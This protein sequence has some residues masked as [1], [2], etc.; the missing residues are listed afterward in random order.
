LANKS[1][2]NLLIEYVLRNVKP[3]LPN[4]KY[5]ILAIVSTIFALNILRFTKTIYYPTIGRITY[6][7]IFDVTLTGSEELD[8]SFVAVGIAT[9]ILLTSS[10]KKFLFIHTISLAVIFLVYILGRVFLMSTT[11]LFLTIPILVLIALVNTFLFNKPARLSLNTVTGTGMSFV[12]LFGFILLGSVFRWFIYGFLNGDVYSDWTWHLADIQNQLFYTFGRLSPWLMILLLISWLTRPFLRYMLALIKIRI[13][14]QGSFNPKYSNNKLSNLVLV[15]AL[16]LSYIFS[17]LPY[18]S[19]INPNQVSIGV[20]LWY[21]VDWIEQMLL[22]SN[23]SEVGQ[24]AFTL[25][26]GDRPLVLFFMYFLSSLSNISPI[27]I[28]QNMPIIIGSLVVVSAYVTVFYATKDRWLAS[29]TSLVAS[30]SYHT[31]VGIY[32]GFLAQW[33]LIAEGYLFLLSVVYLMNAPQKK[34]IILCFVLSIA[35][36]TTHGSWPFFWIPSAVY[37]IIKIANNRN[38]TQL[39]RALP[40]LI[41]LFSVIFLDLLRLWLVGSLLGSGIGRSVWL[42][43][44]W[45]YFSDFFLR[46]TNLSVLFNIFVGGFYTN[47]FLLLIAFIGVISIDTRSDWGLI[48]M[49]TLLVAFIPS[50]LGNF[51]DQSRLF[52]LLPIPMLAAIG[53]RNLSRLSNKYGFVGPGLLLFFILSQIEYAVRSLSNMIM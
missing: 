9:L 32:A 50:I 7:Q 20:D 6:E 40:L 13:S 30:T 41:I 42:A 16:L 22:G 35:M 49:S 45:V 24:K 21:Y 26:G 31:I 37:V 15:S 23:I 18:Q 53:I 8:L 3:L 10:N 2:N 51:S 28:A 27:L 48:L 36:L 4:I 19:A 29:L 46:W 12:A 47:S 33:L 11:L 14:G 5:F 39:R 43:S 34:N 38:K 44:N 52:F 1:S 17:V 25:A